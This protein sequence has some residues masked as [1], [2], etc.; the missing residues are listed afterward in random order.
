MEVFPSIYGGNESIIDCLTYLLDFPHHFL[1][2]LC[3]VKDYPIATPS[4]GQG[5][6]Q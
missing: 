3:V 2:T 6:V 1:K 4:I 5:I